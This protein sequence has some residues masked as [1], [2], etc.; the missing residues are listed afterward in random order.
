M[1]KFNEH[2]KKLRK[3]K[4]LTQ[5]QIS[6]LIDVKQG[7]YSRWESG[8]L[9]P[10]NYYL[11]QLAK[12]FEVSTDYLLGLEEKNSL[13]YNHDDVL[14]DK[15]LEI[16]DLIEKA[17]NDIEPKIYSILSKVEFQEF[18]VEEVAKTLNEIIQRLYKIYHIDIE[19]LV[20]YMIKRWIT[21]DK[22]K[23]ELLKLVNKKD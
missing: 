23:Q 4:N 6:E 1:E 9:E 20:K 8:K 13:L 12:A 14:S 18:R 7:T 16:D 5:T 22:Q 19:P 15:I 17:Y 11:M 3:E 2:L 21:F 10:N